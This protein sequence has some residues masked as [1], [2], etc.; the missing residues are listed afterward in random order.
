MNQSRNLLKSICSLCLS[1]LLLTGCKTYSSAVLFIN[2]M[3]DSDLVIKANLN[4][5]EYI[6]YSVRAKSILNVSESGKYYNQ[7]NEVSVSEFVRNPNAS[8]RVYIKEGDEQ[9]FVREWKYSDKD[10]EGK[11]FFNE[12]FLTLEVHQTSY[13][14]TCFQYYFAI[15]HDDIV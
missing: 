5:E 8:V 15:T 12:L 3:T 13:G 9:T 7:I 4:T 2:N 10:S 14:V 1:L 11:Q 6:E